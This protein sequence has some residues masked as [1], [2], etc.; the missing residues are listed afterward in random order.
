MKLM[1]IKRR[2][3][4]VETLR[5]RRFTIECFKVVKTHLVISGLKRRENI[6]SVVAALW[7]LYSANRSQI[8]GRNLREILQNL[9]QARVALTS[10]FVTRDLIFFH[11]LVFGTFSPCSSLDCLISFTKSERD[12]DE[13]ECKRLISEVFVPF[14]AFPS[15]F[16]ICKQHKCAHTW[17]LNQ[18]FVCLSWRIK[19]ICFGQLLWWH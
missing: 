13:Y 12:R 1:N 11:R 14:N 10:Q 2:P 4:N 6:Q 18:F 5:N 8:W 15:I 19:G 3:I 9:F 17:M 7:T 16:H